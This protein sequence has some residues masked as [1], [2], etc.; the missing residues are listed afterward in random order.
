[1][2]DINKQ[3]GEAEDGRPKLRCPACSFMVPLPAENCPQ[4]RANLRSGIVP[5]SE[6]EETS[7][8]GRLIIAGLVL[9][10]IIGLAVVFFSGVLNG[11]QVPAADAPAASG[12]SDGIGEALDA[13]QELPDQNIGIRPDIVLDRAKNTAEQAEGRRRME[14]ET[15]QYQPQ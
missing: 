10:V 12:S 5:A 13:F 6:E 14:E 4:C 1:M 2:S 15:E 11:P 3:T 8:R 9:L 7:N